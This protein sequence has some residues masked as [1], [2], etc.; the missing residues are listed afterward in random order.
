MKNNRIFTSVV[1]LLSSQVVLELSQ[2]I[3]SY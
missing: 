1:N 2:K 3:G